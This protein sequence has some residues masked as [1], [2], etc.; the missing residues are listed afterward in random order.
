[1]VEEAIEKQLTTKGIKLDGN[2]PDNTYIRI[3]DTVREKIMSNN[4]NIDEFFKS[5][6]AV[7]E[8]QDLIWWNKKEVYVGVV[9]EN[10]KITLQKKP[11]SQ[12]EIYL[13]N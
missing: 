10:I 8:K 4:F 5:V 11:N 13:H 9:W 6:Q 7:I 12:I 3:N 2:L 1:M